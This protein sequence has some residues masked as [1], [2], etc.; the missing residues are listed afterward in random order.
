MNRGPYQ[1]TVWTTAAPP[2]SSHPTSRTELIH[3]TIAFLV[4]TGDLFIILSGR[5]FLETGTLSGLIAPVAL[6]YVLLAVAAALTGFIAHEMAHKVVARRLGYWAEFRMWPMGLLLSIITSVGG[7]LFAAPGATMVE[8]MDPRDRRGWG[9]T[10]VAGPVSNLLFA[11][12]F[13]GASLVTFH[14]GSSAS[15]GLLFLAMINTLFATFN[16]LPLGILDGAKVFRWGAGRWALSFAV[17]AAFL[18]VSYTAYYSYG[19]PFLAW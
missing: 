7:V 16:L 15:S 12:G 6:Y 1:Y 8:G 3:V 10:G 13:Y 2:L 17:A 5:G 19:S 14:L 9:E 18:A 4:L 11:A